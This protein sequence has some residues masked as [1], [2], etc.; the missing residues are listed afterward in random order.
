MKCFNLNNDINTFCKKEKCRYWIDKKECGNCTISLVRSREKLTLE[1]IGR[2]FNV[3]RM[4]VCQIEKIAIKK[5]K[6][7]LKK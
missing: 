1:E 3:T 5:I 6:E 4:R 2:I 7:K